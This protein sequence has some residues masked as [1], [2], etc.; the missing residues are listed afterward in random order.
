MLM[1]TRIRA[2]RDRVTTPRCSRHRSTVQRS[3]PSPRLDAMT[4]AH[5]KAF[6]AIKSVRDDVQVGWSLALVDMQA[7]PGGDERLA[8]MRAAAQLDWLDVS[9]DDDF[10]A[11]A[12]L[13]PGVRRPRRH[14]A[15]PRG[16]PDCADRMGDLP[17]RARSTR[18]GWRRSGR[19][20]RSSSPRT[21]S[22][23]PTT[24]RGARTPDGALSGL[25][26]RDR[27]RD[28]RARVPALDAARQLRMD[29]GL[30]DHVRPHRLRP[31]DVR[32]HGQAVSPLARRDRREL[33]AIGDALSDHRSLGEPACRTIPRRSWTPGRRSPS[34][35]LLSATGAGS[36]TA[37]GSTAAA[38]RPVRT[39][40]DASGIQPGR[41]RRHRAVDLQAALDELGERAA[42]SLQLD[43]GSL[44][45]RRAAVPP[46]FERRAARRRQGRDHPLLHPA[47]G[48]ERAT[49]A[50]SGR[51]PAGRSSS[52]ARERLAAS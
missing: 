15:R 13:L 7:A 43:A 39:R 33:L 10:V 46:R 25:A 52:F 31:H 4:A 12:D 49:R 20:G 9:R 34:T 19:A 17:R 23:R 51:G 45:A 47:L 35:H 50:R 42:A 26:R 41:T 29:V 2:G 5:R 40:R 28:R 3:W 16:C 37:A 27:R 11:R 1:V 8:E 14:A 48:R 24:T 30:Q 18:C 36:D 38:H 44:R 22:P 6:D 21:G 32:T